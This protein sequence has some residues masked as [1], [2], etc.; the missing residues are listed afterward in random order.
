[1]QCWGKSDPKTKFLCNAGENPTRKQS[2]YAMQGKIQSDFDAI[3]QELTP[4][5]SLDLDE[6]S[7]NDIFEV[8][9]HVLKE[10][11]ISKLLND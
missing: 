10:D 8:H 11:V 4:V 6:I 2:F 9:E 3:L 7:F 1:M 5:I